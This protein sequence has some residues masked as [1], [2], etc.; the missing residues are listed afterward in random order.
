MPW[1]QTMVRC[2]NAA[3]TPGQ[4]LFVL[5]TPY[6]IEHL[7]AALCTP[8][9]APTCQAVPVCPPS[10]VATFTAPPPVHPPC[11]AVAALTAATP[12]PC[13]Q[14]VAAPVPTVC[15]DLPLVRLMIEYHEASRCGDKA[16]GSQSRGPVH[17]HRPDLL[18]PV[19]V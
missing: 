10:C 13:V 5:T 15:P 2:E 4:H 12:M 8:A 1:G 3:G 9:P 16:R 7:D 11:V 19:S 17:R 14:P 18:Q 6:L